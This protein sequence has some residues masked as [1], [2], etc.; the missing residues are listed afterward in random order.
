MN[1]VGLGLCGRDEGGVWT[2][3]TS[4]WLKGEAFSQGHWGTTVGVWAGPQS[5]VRWC[6]SYRGH[7]GRLT[8]QFTTTHLPSAKSLHTPSLGLPAA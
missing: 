4:A 6:F 5:H 3:A 2:G 8:L 7:S 1:V